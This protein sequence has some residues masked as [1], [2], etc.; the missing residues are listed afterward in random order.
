VRQAAW[1]AAPR[2]KP[3]Q[4]SGGY[5]G[6]IPRR[7]RVPTPAG[8]IFKNATLWPVCRPFSHKPAHCLDLSNHFADGVAHEALGAL[9]PEVITSAED[10]HGP[11]PGLVEGRL[12]A[13]RFLLGLLVLVLGRETFRGAEGEI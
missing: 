9:E 2:A 13:S 1:C 12:L 6:A 10:L 4:S 7:R 8:A 11:S 3:S 5:G